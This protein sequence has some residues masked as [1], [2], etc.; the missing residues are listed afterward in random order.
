MR[1][2]LDA[3]SDFLI[4]PLIFK[5]VGS[6]VVAGVLYLAIKLRGWRTPPE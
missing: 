6:V 1:P 5:I 2:D 4:H 3:I